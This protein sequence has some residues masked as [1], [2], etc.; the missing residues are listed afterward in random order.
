MKNKEGNRN[1]TIESPFPYTTAP[2]GIAIKETDYKANTS[3]NHSDLIS[4]VSSVAKRNK[5]LD[6]WEEYTKYVDEMGKE[7][8][9]CIHCHTQTYSAKTSSTYMIPHAFECKLK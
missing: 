9:R 4:Q 8:L 2:D 6:L 7:R 5:K 3:I 1:E